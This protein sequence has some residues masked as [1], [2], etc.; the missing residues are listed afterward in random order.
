MTIFLSAAW[1]LLLNFTFHLYVQAG[2]ILATHCARWSPAV[3]FNLTKFVKLCLLL[4]TFTTFLLFY[5]LLSVN[6]ALTALMLLFSR[7]CPGRAFKRFWSS[8]EHLHQKANFLKLLAKVMLVSLFLCGSKIAILSWLITYCY[9][10][11]SNFNFPTFYSQPWNLS[12]SKR[13]F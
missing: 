10:F 4:S 8:D 13:I 2:S 3:R 5:A 1:F 9:F 11:I 7:L 6:C 12:V